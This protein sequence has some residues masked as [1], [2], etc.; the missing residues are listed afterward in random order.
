VG[1]IAGWFVEA[2]GWST[3]YL[4]SVAASVPGI[5][6]LLVCK[7]TLEY[8]QR[9]ERFMPR[10]QYAGAYRLA[11][12]MLSVGCLLLAA[13]LI[14]LISNSLAFTDWSVGTQLL[15][16]G[17]LLAVAGIVLGGLLDYLALRKTPQASSE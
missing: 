5:L 17:G 16:T 8:T 7:S 12:R 10:H 14:I 6:L 11:L 15:E 9:T 4:F 13:W 2:H 1:P 3:F